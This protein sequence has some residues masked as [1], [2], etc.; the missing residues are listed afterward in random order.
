MPG[1]TL[2]LDGQKQA[3]VNCEPYEVASAGVKGTVIEEEFASV[4][5]MAGSY[6]GQS[7]VHHVWLPDLV[8]L[9][10]QLVEIRFDDNSQTTP[11]GRTLEE[12]FPDE[13]SE[14]PWQPPASLAD[15]FAQLRQKPALRQGFGFSLQ[16]SS[17]AAYEGR[18]ASGDHGFGLSVLWNS[19]RPSRV[20]VSL[21][22]YTLDDLEQKSPLRDHVREYLEIGGWV[23]LRTV[24]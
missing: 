14:G 21:H 3:S 7:D 18:T 22:S 6:S 13:S 2:L 9:P 23:A 5:L 15:T 20:S 4:D 1:L 17:G 16:S 12:L 19:V 10:G 24:A 11:A 8:L